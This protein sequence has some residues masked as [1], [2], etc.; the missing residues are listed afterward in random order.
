MNLSAW[1]VVLLFELPP[2][3]AKMFGKHIYI[4]DE[5][6]DLMETKSIKN[7]CCDGEPL[8]LV[9]NNIHYNRTKQ[10]PRIVS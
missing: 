10:A 7:E 1:I 3:L 5:N 9:Y 2:V 6:G 4:Y 8:F